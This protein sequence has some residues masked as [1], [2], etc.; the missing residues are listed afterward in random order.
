MEMVVKIR[1][2][3][4]RILVTRR[5]LIIISNKG[6]SLSATSAGIYLSSKVRCYILPFGIGAAIVI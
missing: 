4:R 5:T 6:G 2:I 1:L 3:V